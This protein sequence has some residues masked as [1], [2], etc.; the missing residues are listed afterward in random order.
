MLGCVGV[1]V[2]VFWLG[3]G[4]G[5]GLVCLVCVVCVVV[6]VVVSFAGCAVA[7]LLLSGGLSSDVET[8]LATFD[9]VMVTPFVC[10]RLFEF[11]T[12]DIRS[13]E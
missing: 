5:L 4:L 3:S 11:L 9:R 1:C 2:T 10:P 12:V 13:P 6:V 7:C 8:S